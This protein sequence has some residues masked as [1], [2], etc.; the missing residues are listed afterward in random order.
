[1]GDEMDTTSREA[2]WSHAN[3]AQ[4]QRAV[5]YNAQLPPA[6]DTQ[7]QK[8]QQ[9][10]ARQWRQVRLDSFPQWSATAAA[11]DRMDISALCGR[12]G[13]L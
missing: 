8:R 3:F 12:I 10:S 5:Q 1:M 6:C 11:A 4:N 9:C 2:A 13:N 7:H